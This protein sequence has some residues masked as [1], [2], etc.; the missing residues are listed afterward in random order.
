MTEWQND[1]MTEWQ[2]QENRQR[3]RQRDAHPHKEQRHQQT[4]AR[5]RNQP[6]YTQNSELMDAHNESPRVHAPFE[7]EGGEAVNVEAVLQLRLFGG[8]DGGKVH[9]TVSVGGRLLEHGRQVLA[10]SAPVREAV[11][12]TTEGGTVSGDGGG[13][14]RCFA[15]PGGEEL[16]QPDAIGSAVVERF[17]GEDVDVLEDTRTDTK[18]RAAPVKA[19]LLQRYRGVQCS[20]SPAHPPQWLTQHRI[21]PPLQLPLHVTP[22]YASKTARSR[23]TRG[24]SL[25]RVN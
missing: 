3:D 14:R 10:V 16:H 18:R 8:V 2:R 9:G 5:R 15:S 20:D 11:D 25:T 4:T 13:C 6:P 24:G 21:P 23:S 19:G 12:T 22:W 17:V 1:R 7:L